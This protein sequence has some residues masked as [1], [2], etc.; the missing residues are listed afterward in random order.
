MSRDPRDVAAPGAP[1]GSVEPEAREP[2]ARIDAEHRGLLAAYVDGVAELSPD[3]RR[4]VESW[5]AREPGARA[6]ADAVHGLIDRLRALPSHDGDEPDWGAMERSIRLAVGDEVPRR[7]WRRWRWLVPTMTFATAAAVLLLIWPRSGEPVRAVP[8]V[9][10][11]ATTTDR[12]GAAPDEPGDGVVALWLDGAEVDIDVSAPEALR[13]LLGDAPPRPGDP[14]ELEEADE[15]GLL[16]ATDLAWV[17]HLDDAA[18][19]RAEHWLTNPAGLT[20]KKG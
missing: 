20:G 9:P 1:T 12:A 14:G 18:L 7:W 13:D 5:L 11:P 17:D 2:E 16:P 19:D 6:D 4:P 15:V 10:A 8:H 3:E